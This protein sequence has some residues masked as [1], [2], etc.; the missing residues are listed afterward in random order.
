[1]TPA[2]LPPTGTVVPVWPGS[3][4]GS[5]EWTWTE[6]ESLFDGERIVRN[7][8]VPTLEVFAA[9]GRANGTAVIV[10]PGGAF[11]LLAI[12]NEGTEL[13][14]WLGERGIAGFVLRYRLARTPQDDGEMVRFQR[15]LDERLRASPPGVGH[16]TP[17]GEESER[18]MAM[19]MADGRQAVRLLR[20]HAHLWGL[21]P[22]R[23]GFVGFSA[24]AA[25]AVASA[26]STDARSRPDFAAPIYGLAPSDL[27]APEAAGPLFLVHAVDDPALPPTQSVAIWQAWH[28]SGRPAEL[29]VF[30]TGGH[31]FGMNRLGLA[32]DSWVSLFEK[33]MRGLGL[34]EAAPGAQ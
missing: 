32:S 23:I 1:M 13:A 24:G 3:P 28:A 5:E 31:G 21:D 11:H 15:A 19:A 29:H 30:Q 33:W 9:A 34:L 22:A 20:D 16:G 18:V 12:D 17:I 25:V 14:R 4:P 27:V 7:V 2:A 26:A 10:A 8:S 6:Q